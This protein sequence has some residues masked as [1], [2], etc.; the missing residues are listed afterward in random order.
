MSVLQDRI[1]SN[2]FGEKY[3]KIFA[4]IFFLTFLEDVEYSESQSMNIDEGIKVLTGRGIC[5]NTNT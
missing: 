1:K 2:V 3:I 4:L 5:C